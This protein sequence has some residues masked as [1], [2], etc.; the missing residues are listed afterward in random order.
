M[1]NALDSQQV[2][3]V[4]R[5][6]LVHELM[7]AGFEVALPM[8]D[9]GVDLLVSPPDYDWTLPVQLKTSRDKTMQVHRKYLGRNIVVAYTLL[10]SSLPSL[11]EDETGVFNMKGNDFSSRTFWLTPEEAWHLPTDNGLQ[12]DLENH[13]DYKFSWTTAL[14]K[15]LLDG[16]VALHR[17]QFTSVVE[18]ARSRLA[19]I[20]ANAG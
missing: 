2:E 11:P 20:R 4:G 13:P 15:G 3:I 12:Q 1:S 19:T 6:W 8:R 14:D 9:R 17:K 5:N 16:K 10:G 18:D 7:L